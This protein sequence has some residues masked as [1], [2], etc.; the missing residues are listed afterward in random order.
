MSIVFKVFN[1]SVRWLL[2]T[3]PKIPPLWN[4]ERLQQEHFILMKWDW[5]RLLMWMDGFQLKQLEIIGFS[6]KVFWI[7]FYVLNILVGKQMLMSRNQ[8][9]FRTMQGT[10]YG[11]YILGASQL[12]VPKMNGL[13][14]LK[15]ILCSRFEFQSLVIMQILDCMY[16]YLFCCSGEVVSMSQTFINGDQPENARHSTCSTFAVLND[17]L[18]GSISHQNSQHSIEM[19]L[20]MQAFFI[21]WA[22]FKILHLH[23]HD[24]F[25]HVRILF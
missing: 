15:L 8:L 25:Q 12:F 19:C 5:D 18:L 1:L 11:S 13:I 6:L 4:G 14:A 20:L 17:D 10:M 24:T 23:Q 16:M 2:A 7:F 21:Y 22:S 3:C 9:S